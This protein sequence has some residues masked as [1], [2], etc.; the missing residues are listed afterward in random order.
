MEDLKQ[1][2]EFFSKPLNEGKQLD[3]EDFAKVVQAVTKTGHPVTVLLVPKFNEIEIITGMDAPDDMLRDLSNAVDSLG[4]GRNDIIIAGD[5]SNLSRREYSDIRRVNGGHKD[6]FEESLNEVKRPEPDY[7]QLVKLLIMAFKHE[8]K[9]RFYFNRNNGV[10]YFDLIGGAAYSPKKSKMRDIFGGMNPIAVNREFGRA[11]HYEEETIK[12]VEQLSNGKI[13]AEIKELGDGVLYKLASVNEATKEEE[14]TSIELKPVGR[15]TGVKLNLRAIKKHLEKNGYTV[16]YSKGS[17]MVNPK[18]IDVFNPNTGNSIVIARNGELF[19]DGNWGVEVSTDK[20]AIQALKQFENELNESKPLK[21]NTF[22]VGQK[23]TYLGHPAV[24]TATKE[25]NGRNFVSVSYDKGTGATK[26]PMILATSGD[27]KPLEE[28]KKLTYNNFIQM[29]RDDMMAG[30]APDE[31]PSDERVRKDAKYL[32]NRYLQGA[33]IEDLF[34]ATK[35]EEN[36]FHKKLDKLVHKTFGHSSDEKKYKKGDKLKIKLK[37]G[38][39]FDVI[40]DKYLAQDGMAFGKI[41]DE[42]GEFDTKPF[43]LDTVV[44]YNTGIYYHPDKEKYAKKKTKKPLKEKEITVDDNAEFKLNLKHLLD[45]HLIQKEDLSDYEEKEADYD[46]LYSNYLYKMVKEV[47]TEK[48]YSKYLKSKDNPKG[49]TDGLD[50]KTMNKILMNIVKDIKE[51][52]QLKE[53]ASTEEKRIAMSAIK[54]IAKY[55]GVDEDEARNDLIRAAKELGSLKEAIKEIFETIELGK[56]L[57]EELCPKGKAYIKKRQAA[58]EKS[59]AYL[60]G[61]AVKVCKGQ[62]KG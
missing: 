10:V 2:Q 55:R 16:N 23:V 32:Y 4:Y 46:E 40:F 57:N 9:A 7:K 31:Y 47:A 19:G 60:S 5:S 48:G 20:E 49:E 54:R 28:N 3:I 38:K 50:T 43:A 22:K 52:N 62:M 12:Q 13:K 18:V 44:E 53:G 21:E 15:D 59:S 36:E 41:K 1:I 42:D 8:P 11:D 61:R 30:A 26:A 17:S 27:V 56:N 29:V 24:V 35:E 25:Y 51:T 6:Y 58:G 45:K 14:G 34:E 33:S 39:E 37:N